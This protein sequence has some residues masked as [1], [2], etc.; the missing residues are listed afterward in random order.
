[1]LII[2]DLINRRFFLSGYNDILIHILE[3]LGNDVSQ[4]KKC[5]IDGNKFAV[6]L[7]NI[8]SE[9][10]LKLSPRWNPRLDAKRERDFKFHYEGTSAGK[11]A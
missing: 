6:E 7:R 9:K 11:R 10:M 5:V 3:L 4:L 2:H 1:M 8:C